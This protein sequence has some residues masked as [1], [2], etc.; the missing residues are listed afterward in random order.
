MVSVQ[1]YALTICSHCTISYWISHYSKIIMSKQ[2]GPT[3]KKRRTSYHFLFWDKGL[4]PDKGHALYQLRKDRFGLTQP[5]FDHLQ[6]QLYVSGCLKVKEG[7]TY[8]YPATTSVGFNIPNEVYE[9]V[10]TKL[11]IVDMY[12]FLIWRYA[13]TKIAQPSDLLK[14]FFFKDALEEIRIE[15]E[16]PENEIDIN[17]HTEDELYNMLETKYQNEMKDRTIKKRTKIKINEKYT[18]QGV[19]WTVHQR[20]AA[21]NTRDFFITHRIEKKEYPMLS[22]IEFTESNRTFVSQ[23]ISALFR[24]NVSAAIISNICFSCFGISNAEFDL[25]AIEEITMSEETCLYKEKVKVPSQRSS[26]TDFKYMEKENNA[27]HIIQRAVRKWLAHR[28]RAVQII[29]R[30]WF[31]CVIENEV[32]R[33]VMQRR[34]TATFDEIDEQDQ[35]K[36]KE[37]KQEIKQDFKELMVEKNRGY[38]YWIKIYLFIL[39]GCSI[40]YVLNSLNVIYQGREILIIT[41]WVLL[42]CLTLKRLNKI[43][44]TI[45]TSILLILTCLFLNIIMQVDNV[46]L[47]LFAYFIIVNA[48]RQHWLYG[49]VIALIARVALSFTNFEYFVLRPNEGFVFFY[50]IYSVVTIVA[51]QRVGDPI[52]MLHKWMVGIIIFTVIAGGVALANIAVLFGAQV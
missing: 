47:R 4:K 49:L 51:C 23:F 34:L 19:E 30:W 14:D 33:E 52:E 25:E 35:F 6:D 40:E 24:A 7:Y 1:P 21:R 20:R 8:I 26:I 5:Q 10:A 28:I 39:I 17:A 18:L 41:P 32:E 22:D 48:S 16:P 9:K 2:A 37:F 46:A 31:P 15:E 45:Q 44:I 11:N 12:N 3:T 29:E 36:Y 38:L 50:D 27:A 43:V 42:Q 13:N